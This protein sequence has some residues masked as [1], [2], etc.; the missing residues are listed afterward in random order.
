MWL[1][2]GART[3]VE[4]ELGDRAF[5]YWD[6]G[7]PFWAATAEQRAAGVVPAGG[8]GSHRAEPGWYADPGV[9][10]I[11]IGRSCATIDHVVGVEIRD[12][13]RGEGDA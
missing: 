10:D 9:Y 1:D 3:T 8:G 6:P 5:S 12:A 2:A 4:L 11:R 7:D 13:H